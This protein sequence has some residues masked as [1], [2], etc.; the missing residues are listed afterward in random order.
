[1]GGESEAG[2]HMSKQR[3]DIEVKDEGDYR[4]L[5]PEG[6]L[7]VY[8]S[9]SLREKL[10]ELAQAGST[11]V[12]V[13]LD[14]V[15]FMDSSGLGVIMGGQRRLREAGGELALKCTQEQHLS[16]LAT[17]EL[18]QGTSIKDTVEEA[19]ASLRESRSSS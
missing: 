15:S 9:G 7:D 18:P 19:A 1:M 14:E 8:T 13:D 3:I 4:V 2:G 6:A 16:L 11:N 12:V 10:T 5:A 17:G